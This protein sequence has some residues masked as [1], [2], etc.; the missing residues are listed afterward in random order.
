MLGGCVDI[1]LYGFGV[2]HILLKRG[3]DGI[4]PLD[5][6]LACLNFGFVNS[7]LLCW[8]ATEYPRG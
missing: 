6:S 4:G 1:S 8:V 7:N 2:D 5:P 3:V